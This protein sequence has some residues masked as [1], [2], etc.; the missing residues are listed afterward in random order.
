MSK[1]DREQLP[2]IAAFIELIAE[3]CDDFAYQVGVGG[4]ET[5]GHLISY[6]WD[7]P[8][9]L[10]PFLNGGFSELPDK[11]LVQG[12]LTY[13]GSDG[14]VRHQREARY[15]RIIAALKETP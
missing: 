15:S 1:F 6:L 4:V 8:N 7:H 12:E 2:I 10:E 13:H 5:A 11:W 14:K 9:D 3:R